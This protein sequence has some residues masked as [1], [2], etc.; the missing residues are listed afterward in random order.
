MYT[1]GP[2]DECK[3]SLGEILVF[4]CRCACVFGW[5]VLDLKCEECSGRPT[6]PR[7]VRLAL[8]SSSALRIGTIPLAQV[9]TGGLVGSVSG[10][11]ESH[12]SR[13]YSQGFKKPAITNPQQI[14]SSHMKHFGANN[15]FNE[16]STLLH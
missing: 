2:L 15:N 7:L 8:G 10:N 16:L 11:E 5:V 3:I 12:V 13:I 4:G 9:S 1:C 6:S 14:N